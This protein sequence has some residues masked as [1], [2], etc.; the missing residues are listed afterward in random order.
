MRFPVDADPDAL[1]SPWLAVIDVFQNASVPSE[2][3]EVSVNL[4]RYTPELAFRTHVDFYAEEELDTCTIDEP[5]TGDEGGED[6]I[7]PSK[8]SVNG[9]DAL[10][11]SSAGGT[12]IS[13]P[14]SRERTGYFYDPDEE[15]FSGFSGPVP[16]DLTLS[17]PGAEFPAVDALPIGIPD[18]PLRL[19]P[20]IDEAIGPA[21][22]YRW[23]PGDDGAIVRVVFKHFVDG[24]F[25]GFPVS[26]QAR[27]DGAF[28]LPENALEALAALPGE[29][30]VRY[31][32]ELERVE[33]RD[34]IALFQ[35]V[36]IVDD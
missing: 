30:T 10:T 17:L 20:P 18:A 28:E 31:S 12:W 13:V 19:S 29:T 33:F 16:D 14:Y 11:L 9:G 34:G 23:T 32:R 15:G 3:G 4:V 5:D 26:C 2:T 8:R 35:S 25:Q 27:D 1:T 7:D 6:E 24:D 22:E 21:T 36:D